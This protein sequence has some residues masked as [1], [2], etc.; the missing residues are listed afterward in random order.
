MWI[1]TRRTR[2]SREVRGRAVVAR[3]LRLLLSVPVAAAT[4]P[5]TVTLRGQVT[6]IGLAG[7]ILLLGSDALAWSYALS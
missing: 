3:A 4:I 6:A 1:M 2:H 7:A 5:T